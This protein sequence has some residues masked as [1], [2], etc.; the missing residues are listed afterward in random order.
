MELGAKL[1]ELGD[2]GDSL[3]DGFRITSVGHE[4]GG[5]GANRADGVLQRGIG[6][7]ENHLI[8]EPRFQDGLAQR[9]LVVGARRDHRNVEMFPFDISGRCDAREIETTADRRLHPG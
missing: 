7:E 6:A 5:A 4:V 8:G 9:N 1:G 3:D 2:F